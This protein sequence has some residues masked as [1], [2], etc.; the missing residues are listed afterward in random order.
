MRMSFT[1]FGMPFA[2][3]LTR[4][5]ELTRNLPPDALARIAATR[6][7]TGI[8]DGN[9]ASWVRISRASDGALSG[10]LW[11]GAELYAIE[12]FERVATNV[13]AGPALG[14]A[15]TV[16]YRWSDT[17][18]AVTDTPGSS[19]PSASSGSQ[20]ALIAASIEASAAARLELTRAKQIDIGLLADSEFVQ[21]H[22]ANAEAQMLSI[23]NIVDGLFLDQVGLRI[24][25]AELRT[26]SEPDA[27]SS[28]DPSTLLS[29]LG[30]FKYDTPELRGRGLVHL[31]T[32]RELAERPGAPAGSRLLG[33]ANFAAVCDERLAAS[34][35]QYSSVNTSAVVAAHEI[36]HNFGAPHDAEAGSPCASTDDSYIMSAFVNG[37]RQFSDCSIQ[38]MEVEL[39]S[40][41]CLTNVPEN[42]L[43]VQPLSAPAEVFAT[44]DF[45]I[46]F[47]VDYGGAADAIDPRLTIAATNATLGEMSYGAQVYCGATTGANNSCTFSDFSAL[48]GRVPIRLKLI[49]PQ[50]GPAS[51]DLEVT[52]LNDDTPTNNRYRFA[53]DV[54]PDSRFVLVSSTGPRVVKPGESFDVDWVIVNQ[55]QIAATDARAEF[56]LYDDVDFIEAQTPSGAACVPGVVTP[57]EQWLCPVGTVAPGA[58]AHLKLKLRASSTPH[59]PWPGPAA[60]AVMFL[61]MVAAEPLF[62]FQNEWEEFVYISPTIVDMHLDSV[63]APASAPVG[64]D[65]TISVRVGNRGPDAATDA[66]VGLSSWTGNGLTFNSVASSRGSCTKLSATVV[67]C[68]LGTLASGEMVEVVAQATMDTQ[69]RDFELVLNAATSTAVDA[70][71]TDNERRIALQAAGPAAPPP[72]STP[73]PASS[74]PP[75]ASPTSVPSPAPAPAASGGGGGSADLALLLLLVCAA[76][77]RSR[78]YR[79][80]PR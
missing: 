4:N 55:G 76:A 52:S 32:G 22:G 24:N 41:A 39:A 28:T 48:G 69:A 18:S 21:L 74:P 30:A 77:C 57:L 56:R 16:I 36:A 78:R 27:F 29:E 43:S 65:V 70:N 8:L 68:P 46:E 61:K 25:V 44:R 9:A 53:F 23:I 58:T 19:A 66:G 26:Y 75:A 73:P 60:T 13:V 72:V 51:I 2:M 38:Q 47:A 31:L 17:L 14:P 67:S 5:E 6:F 49:G 11:D 10:A 50:L 7:Y 63:V 71:P 59:I 3:T 35:T 54:V 45:E 15:E 34:L 20:K 79:R 33:I 37:S 1:A 64:S 80:A 12:S 42:D 62:N 40:A